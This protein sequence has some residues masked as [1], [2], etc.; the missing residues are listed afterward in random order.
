MTRLFA[1]VP[2]VLVPAAA[3]QPGSGAGAKRRDRILLA[4]AKL[5]RPR[6]HWFVRARHR[7]RKVLGKT[8]CR[9]CRPSHA[10]AAKPGARRSGDL[11]AVERTD[12]RGCAGRT[13]MH[14]GRSRQEH[15]RDPEIACFQPIR[16]CNLQFSQR[17]TGALLDFA[18]PTPR[19]H[20][21]RYTVGV[22]A[23][24]ISIRALHSRLIRRHWS[25]TECALL[26]PLRCHKSPLGSATRTSS[27]PSTDPGSPNYWI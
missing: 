24:P 5:T 19:R 4:A 25:V 18:G 13:R 2:A 12:H 15:R 7:G 10:D 21:A 20:C 3:Q 27:F 16:Y 11:P 1:T 26:R 22:Q 9:R 8:I 23:Q 6:A 14:S 17:R